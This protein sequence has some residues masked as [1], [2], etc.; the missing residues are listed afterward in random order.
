VPWKVLRDA[1]DAISLFRRCIEIRKNEVATL[2]WDIVISR[3]AV[4][5]AAQADPNSARADIEAGMRQR[6]EPHIARCARF[7]ETPD[8]RNGYDFIAWAKQVLEEH[9]VLD[10]LAIY[11]RLTRGGDLFG[12]EVIDG[13]TIKPLLDE[14]GGRPM[15]PYPAYQ[16]VLYGFPRGEYVADVDEKGKVQGYAADR[17]IYRVS[18]VRAFTPYG[19]SAV[20]QALVDGDLY[21]RRHGWLKAEYTDGVMPSGWLLAG[22]GQANWAP[23]QLLAYETALN[24]Y[25][26]GSTSNR[27]RFR[28]LPWGMTPADGHGEIGERYKPDYDLHL[29]KLVA[30]HFDTTIAELGFTEVGGL[31]STGWHEGQA[32]VQGRKATRPTMAMLQALVTDVSRQFLGMPEEL[33]FRILGLES[34][35]EDAS[36]EVADRRLKAGRL[37]VN[38]DRDRQGMPRFTTPNADRPFLMTARGPVFLDT[39]DHP[40]DEAVNE[41]GAQDDE[42]GADVGDGQS[43][44]D[45]EQQQ[46]VKSAE[47]AA[48]TRWARRT[49]TGGRPFTF[50]HLTPDQ[51]KAAGVNM[52]HASFK[53]GGADPKA[54][55]PAWSRDEATAQAWAPRLSQASSGALPAKKLVTDYL[56]ARPAEDAN[57]GSANPGGTDGEVDPGQVAAAENWLHEYDGGGLTAALAVILAGAVTEGFLLGAL[58]AAAVLAA[59]PFGAAARVHVDWMGWEPGDPQRAETILERIGHADHLAGVQAA[60]RAV[61]A[62][63]AANRLDDIAR[64][65]AAGS[66]TRQHAENI[67]A[68]I[69]GLTGDPA[70][71]RMVAITEVTRAASAAALV[72]YRAA[73]ISHVRWEVDPRSNVC[74]ACHG[75]ADAGPIPVGSPFP[76][77]DIAPPAHPHCACSLLPAEA[78]TAPTSAYVTAETGAIHGR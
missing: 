54:A 71:A 68:T 67:I 53:A 23:E 75:N 13:S 12:F 2:D 8:R 65:L 76:S 26:A 25:L 18:N 19:F 27:L 40:T 11:P 62:R 28:I 39:A 58:S 44:A 10:A 49:R 63:I 47:L 55:W 59:A 31:G 48:Y 29:I 38:E 45:E 17:L 64:A 36:D 1:A 33:E 57:P 66:A 41:P 42:Q 6:L 20:E 24:D 69:A 61:V 77:G 7:W 78:P 30:A 43:P 56:T 9:F 46:A 14:Q 4:G 51:A 74:V 15:P 22:E 70:W 72:V 5:R 73:G 37:T 32:D 52:A 35:D 60:A 21:L 3:R 50:E 16:Q 34:D